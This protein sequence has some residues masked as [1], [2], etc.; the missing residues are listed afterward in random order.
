MAPEPLQIKWGSAHT[1]GGTLSVELEGASTKAWK[2]RFETVVALLDTPHSGWGDV[3]L[4]K[5]AIK[6]S[7]VQKG[8]EAELR[9]FLESAVLQANTDTA[10]DSI[11]QHEDEAGEDHEPD[12]DEQMTQTFR[13]FAAEHQDS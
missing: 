3:G 2:A 13:G 10:P 12:A 8:S 11:A 6:V 7:N 9:H 5:K 4:T 1:E